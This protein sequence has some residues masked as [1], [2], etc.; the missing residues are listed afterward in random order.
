MLLGGT[1][2]FLHASWTNLKAS[3]CLMIVCLS[4]FIYNSCYSRFFCKASLSIYSYVMS[5]SRLSTCV[6]G[7]LIS[8]CWFISSLV[9]TSIKVKLA[10]SL[11]ARSAHLIHTSAAWRWDRADYKPLI[12]SAEWISDFRWFWTIFSY[13]SHCCLNYSSSK[14]LALSAIWAVLSSFCFSLL[15]LTIDCSRLGKSW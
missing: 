7:C 13:F 11:I 2:S 14:V 12:L 15:S 9:L 1:T 10:L 8:P 5:W 6:S 4:F 3:F